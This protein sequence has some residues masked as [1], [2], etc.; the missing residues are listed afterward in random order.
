ML[1]GCHNRE[2]QDPGID[3][4]IAIAYAINDIDNTHSIGKTN[5]M[6]LSVSRIFVIM[7]HVRLICCGFHPSCTDDGDACSTLRICC[8][9]WI[10]E[11]S[12][13]LSPRPHKFLCCHRATVTNLIYIL[14]SVRA[15]RINR[16]IAEQMSSIC[17]KSRAH[18]IF[19]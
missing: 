17:V 18:C 5:H 2:A 11:C 3:R 19:H 7:I 13:S 12:P 10:K 4:R 9:R 15:L 6:R 16:V 1:P 8:I 14:C